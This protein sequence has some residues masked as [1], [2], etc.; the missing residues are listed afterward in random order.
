MKLLIIN[1][2][3]SDNVTALIEQEARLAAA[4]GTEITMLTAPMG[5]AY[6]ETRF[7]ALIAAYAVAELAATHAESHDA[8]IVAAFG[9]PGLE[10]LR[11]ALDIPVLGMT[12]SALMSACMLGKRFSIIAISR[13]I[14][15][16]YRDI[17]ERNGLLGRL[18]SIRCLDEPLR[19][20]GSVQQD[21]GARLQSLCEAAVQEDRA[22][23][24]IIAGAP[25]AGLARSIKERLP[26]PAVDG[27]SSAVNHAQSLVALA[28]APAK[29]GSF[30]KPPRKDFK[31]LP[32]GLSALLGALP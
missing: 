7:E 22:D 28:P 31:N 17:V 30:A 11:E 21:H 32:P 26:V 13:R 8:L 25:L 12:E 4:P 29:A 16:W 19:D 18:A 3:I 10:G 1:P 14:T 9:D 15:A 5:V 24:L 2:N 23:V 27:V 6:I 20:I